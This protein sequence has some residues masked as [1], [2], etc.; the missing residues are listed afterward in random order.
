MMNWAR[1]CRVSIFLFAAIA[2]ALIA[3][4]PVRAASRQ[5]LDRDGAKALK[6]LYANNK[7]ARML[8]EKALSSGRTTLSSV[9]QTIW[10]RSKYPG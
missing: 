3:T 10:R 2:A 7:A 4:P 8:G 6:S 5:E 1:A 9:P